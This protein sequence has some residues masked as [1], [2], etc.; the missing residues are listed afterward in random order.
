[1]KL[2]MERMK[3]KLLPGLSLAILTLTSG[4]A[5]WPDFEMGEMD[6][7]GFFVQEE[8]TVSV[9]GLPSATPGGEPNLEKPHL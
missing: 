7:S 9:S 2:Q 1:M 3:A 4:C 5:T 6:F 8:T